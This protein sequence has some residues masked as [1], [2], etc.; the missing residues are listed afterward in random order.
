MPSASGKDGGGPPPLT[1][2][3]STVTPDVD[4]RRSPSVGCRSL[5]PSRDN[6]GA[7][8]SRLWISAERPGATKFGLQLELRRT[9]FFDR[10]SVSTLHHTICDC[11]ESVSSHPARFSHPLASACTLLKNPTALQAVGGAV[12]PDGPRDVAIDIASDIVAKK[13]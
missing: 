3:F 4:G 1:C 5:L 11:T 2:A 7:R 12:P 13:V 6:R 9:K 10:T 8:A